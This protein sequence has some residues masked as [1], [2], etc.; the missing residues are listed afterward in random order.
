MNTH[1]HKLSLSL[2]H[3]TLLLP[4][5]LTSLCV[6]T[7][8]SVCALTILNTK[9]VKIIFL[10]YWCF[11][12][13]L[14]VQMSLSMYVSQSIYSSVNAFTHTKL[15]LCVSLSHTH[16]H[17]HSL[18]LLHTDTHTHTQTYIY[19]YLCV[20]VCVWERKCISLSPYSTLT[21]THIYMCVCVCVCLCLCVCV[22]VHVSNSIYH[23][24]ISHIT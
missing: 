20:Y 12:C 8:M 21:H 10:V 6:N 14:N 11:R 7:K 17:F 9:Y 13:V 2:S 24:S 23:L 3:H 22:K 19:I 1:R 15:S 16:S 18:S 5:Y 4:P